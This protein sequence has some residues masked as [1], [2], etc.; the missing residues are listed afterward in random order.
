M[1]NIKKSSLFLLAVLVLSGSFAGYQIVRALGGQGTATIDG[2]APGGNV[3]V[4][5]S[6]SHK[7]TVVL[8]IGA[9]GITVDAQNPTFTIPTGFTAPTNPVATAGDVSADGDWSAVGGA[10]CPIT[11]GSSSNSGQVITVDVT[12]V[13]TVGPGGKITLTY[14]GQSASTMSAAPLVI[15]TA[16][17]IGAGAPTAIA[18]PPTITVTAAAAPT[19][20][21]TMDHAALNIGDTSLVTFTFS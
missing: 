7:F 8:T 5:Q 15:K 20:A 17:D 19:V 2:G 16:V 21:G 4:V 6:T 14:Q 12:T 10:T 11:M 9:D 13:C 18:A 1:K 3:S